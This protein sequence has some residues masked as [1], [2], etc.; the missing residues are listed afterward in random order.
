M[1]KEKQSRNGMVV[2]P[3]WLASKAGADVLRR[4]GNAIE[5]VIAAGAALSVV[6]PH[7][8]GL[9]GDAVWMTADPSGN[10]SCLLG[11]GQAA[12]SASIDNAK[13]T[14]RGP[15]STW[16]TACLVDSWQKLLDL[17]SSQWKGQERLHQLLEP[18]IHLAQEGY[19]V[20]PSQRFWSEFRKNESSAWPGF[21]A[22]FGESGIQR[23]PQ[24]ADTLRSIADE[25]ARGFYE[26]ALAR[27]VAQGLKHA[28]S[29]L[30]ASD[31]AATQARFVEPLGHDYRDMRLFAPPPPTQGVTTLGI[32]GVLAHLDM[33][34]QD[35]HSAQYYHYLVEAVK[36]AFLDRYL[37][38]DPS[39]CDSWLISTLLDEERLSSKAE[40]IDPAKAME[41][42][43]LHRAGDTAFLAAVDA[44]GRCVC[45]LQSLYFDWGS[46]VVVGDTGVLWQNRGAAFSLDPE[47]PNR[48]APGKLPFYTLN[49]GLG[50]RNGRPHLL[51]GTQGA[52]GQPQTLALLLSLLIDH[53]FDL[54]AALAHPRFLLGKTFSDSRDSLKIEANAGTDVFSGLAALGHSVSSIDAFSP[55]G[56]QAGVIR[57]DDD[58]LIHGS[59]DPRSDGGAE[60]P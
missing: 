11:I 10:V 60:A 1:N 33:A 6:Y 22:I 57:I 20:S 44:Q 7:F 19:D 36:K 56:G 2:A 59:H 28:S 54:S 12:A 58:G 21:E 49:P 4:G 51:Y 55:L 43:H 23:Q 38:G 41:W 35:P 53:Q 32:M 8:C 31:L 15:S 3:H 25:G 45:G 47:S 14:L 37:I 30:S 50:L 24:L 42:P 17:S 26:G 52:D 34:G 39:A 46:G 27:R 9:G 48:I 18:A 29:P 5:A 16:T 40:A 13:I